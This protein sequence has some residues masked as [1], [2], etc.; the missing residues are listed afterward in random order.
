MASKLQYFLLLLLSCAIL[1]LTTA[2]DP[3]IL[4]DF[5]PPPISFGPLGGNY[6]TF[7]GMRTLVGAPFPPT[8]KV[9]KAAMAEFPALNGQSFNSDAKSPT[10]AVS[11]FGSANAGTVSV[12]NSV[13]NSTIC[14]EVLAKSFKTDIATIQKIKSGLAG[15]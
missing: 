4:T 14:D 8:F 12:P 11:A 15:K 6:F 13:F 9:T 2:G 7:T 5:I 10:L 1:K 3:D